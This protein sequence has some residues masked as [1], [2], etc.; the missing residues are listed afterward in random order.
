MAQNRRFS[1][2][3]RGQF[4]RQMRCAVGLESPAMLPAGAANFPLRYF[5]KPKTSSNGGQ[6]SKQLKFGC[7]AEMAKMPHH[8]KL[9]LGLEFS[10]ALACFAMPLHI[11]AQ[12]MAKHKFHSGWCACA[13]LGCVSLNLLS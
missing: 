11:A 5:F 13:K 8:E 6:C 1:S 4:M 3:W 10:W 2:V 7:L 12:F 9:M